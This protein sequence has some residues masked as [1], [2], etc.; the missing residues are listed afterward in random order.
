[1]SIFL[2]NF[3][4][5][6]FY[7]NVL[8]L[9]FSGCVTIISLHLLWC[10][11]S[12]LFFFSN[13]LSILNHGLQFSTKY[14]WSTPHNECSEYCIVIRFQVFQSKLFIL[15]SVHFIVWAASYWYDDVGSDGTQNVNNQFSMCMLFPEVHFGLEQ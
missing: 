3:P 14:S 13:C 6:H 12:S 4:T 10:N 15:S 2:N 9:L 11:H 7:R 8:L 5:I 1:M